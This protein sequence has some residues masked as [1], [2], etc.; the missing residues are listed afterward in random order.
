MDAWRER[1]RRVRIRGNIDAVY[2]LGELAIHIERRGNTLEALL[3]DP[4]C[5]AEAR[6]RVAGAVVEVMPLPLDELLMVVAA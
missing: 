3:D 5:V 2:E 1:F 6:L 4:A